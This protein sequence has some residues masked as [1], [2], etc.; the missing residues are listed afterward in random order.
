ME[1]F[2]CNALLLLCTTSSKHYSKSLARL[3]SSTPKF[4]SNSSSSCFVRVQLLKRS[5]QSFADKP[6]SLESLSSTFTFSPKRHTA[7]SV[8]NFSSTL[9]LLSMTSEGSSR[10]TIPFKQSD[11]P[12]FSLCACSSSRN[13]LGPLTSNFIVVPFSLDLALNHV[14]LFVAKSINGNFSATGRYARSSQPLNEHILL[15]ALAVTPCP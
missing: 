3:L 4:L 1:R 12:S 14:V 11:N 9:L 15:K 2:N 10:L 13:F 5:T 6:G 8:L 7:S